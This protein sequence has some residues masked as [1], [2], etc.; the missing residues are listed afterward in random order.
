V[1]QPSVRSL[2]FKTESIIPSV[3]KPLRFQP[4]MCASPNTHLNSQGI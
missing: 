4:L 3:K 1:K 2:A